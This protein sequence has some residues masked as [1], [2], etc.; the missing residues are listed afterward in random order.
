MP[1]EDFPSKESRI[2]SNDITPYDELTKFLEER[3]RTEAEIIQALEIA[4]KSVFELPWDVWDL[5][6][7]EI[8]SIGV[9][10]E[11]EPD[12]ILGLYASLYPVVE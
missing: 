12:V 1:V 10:F 7:S 5:A 6:I 9:E 11:I 2:T 3:Q 8:V 4:I